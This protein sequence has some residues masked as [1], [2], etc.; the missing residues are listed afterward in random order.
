LGSH[1][2]IRAIERPGNFDEPSR[3]KGRNPG[4]D[5]N[6]AISH[7]WWVEYGG[8]MN[9]IEDAEK[10]RDELF[11]ISIGLWNYA[12]NHN[13][14]TKDKNLKRELVWLNYVPGVRESRRLIGDYVM[15]QKDYEERIVHDDTVAFTD[16]GPDVHHPE[17]FWVK[18]NDC[19]HVYQGRRTSIPYRTLYSKNIENL[20]MAGR[21]HSATHIAFGGTRVMRPCCAMGQAVGTAA[22][23]AT[24]QKTTPR[25]VYE[26]H[27]RQLQDTLVEDGCR[28]MDKDGGMREPPVIIEND[29]VRYKISADGKN[30]AFVDRST[31]KDY[32]KRDAQSVCAMVRCKKSEYP[33][34]SV[35]LG[36]GRLVVEF[37]KADAKAVI[38][39]ESR[40]SY[41]YWA[42]ES[43]SGKDVESL[44]FLNVPLTLSG[45]PGEAFG[46]CAFSLNLKTRVNA[47][48]ALQTRLR[49]SCYDKFGMEGA[50]VAIV[51]M[52]VKRML[53]ALKK[54][55]TD[56]DEMPH[57][58][59]A[60]PWA[61]ETPFNQ[62]SYLFNFGLL[63]ESNVDEWI[64][65]A[66]KLGVTQ[67]DNHGGRRFFRF[68]DFE[69][70]RA[71][72]P[73]GWDTYRGIVKRLH[74]AGIGSIFHTYGF[75]ID[76]QSKYVRPVP[77][78]RL[79]AF[80]T[81]TLAEDLDADAGQIAVNESTEGMSTV[82]GFFEHNS[83]ILHIGDELVTFG[84]V[85]QE[86]PWHFTNVQRGAFGTK[87]SAHKAGAKARHLKEC[88]GLLVPDA[89]SSLFE[90]I[91]KNHADIV[92]WC[93][94]DGIYL[95][96]IDGSS[97]LRGA[98]ECWYWADKFIF[99][100]QRHLK[101]PV[102]MEMSA[103]WHHFWQFRTRWQAWDYP[104]RGHKRFIDIHASSVNGGLLLPLHL[105]W[106][107]FQHFN[108][109]QVEPTYPDVI[110]YLGAKL[111]GWDAGISL[112]G[113]IDRARLDSVP[114]F[115]RA[116]DVLRTCEELR[117][118]KAFDESTRAKL[119]E[120]GKEFSLFR[121]ESGKWRFRP[122]YYDCHKASRAEPWSLSWTA[123]NPF[124]EQPV[125]FRLEALMSAASY[126]DPG[127]IVLADFSD[128]NQF[129]GPARGAAGV[130]AT[131]VKAAEGSAGVFSASNSGKVPR[132][133]AWARVDRKFEPNLNLNGH[134]ALG[135]RIEGDGKGEIIAIR[136]ESPRHLAFGAVADRYIDVDFTGSR[137][138]TLV[139]TESE[140]WS[141]YT[142][143]DGKWLYNVYR[144][145]IKFG[146]VESLSI[147]YNNL[148]KGRE[149]AC[150]IGPIKAL[151]MVACT[152]K[153]P[154]ILVN[155]ERITLPV[156]MTS[157][158]YLEFKGDDDCVLYGSKGE[159]IAEV[160]PEGIAPIL[161]A[162]KNHIRFS[163]SDADGPAPRVKLTLISHGE[164]L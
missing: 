119:R 117:R 150:S 140:R 57:C 134:Q 31:G 97:I 22:A 106:W 83:V 124:G 126:D 113:A 6:G 154:A 153:N 137:V 107:N 16:W 28:L 38:R 17:G 145:T 141:D 25:G 160:K 101:K 51:G 63:T 67:I 136:L 36:D 2:R 27:I 73:E 158:S 155:G 5:I 129:A 9:T 104:Q 130:T 59:V 109:P 99:D 90:E 68:G 87:A 62:G 115:R 127:N 94:F 82:T 91:A 102:G 86:S 112:T 30:L 85:S 12:K 128:P 72:W 89:E 132:R 18:G 3:G 131:L 26:E 44:V 116:V 163:C 135:I 42:V 13:P 56:A 143:N 120:P 19:I 75:F 53:P 144:E 8:M 84:A 110:E 151:P 66:R 105:G 39:V 93:D 164:P 50:K 45:R 1:R 114:L 96:A 34:T 138:F 61:Q 64:A 23:I 15:S 111:I 108:P 81:F 58:T 24:K 60:G 161:L 43:V 88:F 152:V 52:P 11:R 157:G 148:P 92:N 142:W 77:D 54:V 125:K 80:R 14:A 95:D 7:A 149:V 146:S 69:L 33:A 156:E 41:I 55:L 100:I 133:G 121:D 70:D 74:E 4:N 20:L 159:F 37:D 49:A 103:M 47:L 65:M 118:A 46:S 79:D 29:H 10:I 98:D 76:K 147:W 139:E 48:P 35:S 21:C 32:L 78:K 123:E 40:Q 162:G 71:K 122:A